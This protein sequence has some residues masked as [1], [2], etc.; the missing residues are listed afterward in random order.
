[1]GYVPVMNFSAEIQHLPEML[2]F[3][4]NSAL[5]EGMSVDKVYKIELASEEALVNIISYAYPH[6]FKEKT[7]SI[8]CRKQGKNRFE[9]LIRDKGVPFNPIEAEINVDLDKSIEQRKIGGLG[10]YMIR[11]LVD[12]VCYQRK[13][14]ENILRIIAIL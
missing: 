9:V 3:I 12:E 13:E 2:K 1:M 5:E 4:R 11:K 6:H 8:E 7:L 14:G 10:I